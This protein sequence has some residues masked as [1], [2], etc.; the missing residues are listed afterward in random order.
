MEPVSLT[1]N[2][3]AIYNPSEIK[4]SIFDFSSI[5]LPLPIESVKTTS[6]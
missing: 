4:E 6:M 1:Y 2:N 5:A 3:K